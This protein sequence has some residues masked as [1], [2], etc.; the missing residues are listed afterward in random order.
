MNAALGAVAHH[1]AQVL[2]HQRLAAHK[3][4]VA[5]VVLDADVDRRPALPSSVTLRRW[6]GIEAV[7]GESAKIAF[8]VADVGD[9][10]LQIA[11]AAV[12]KNFAG[13]LTQASV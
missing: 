5:D 8:G 13:Q 11:R 7:H 6:L 10:E 9:G 2:V 12:R 4:Q 3:E 1:R